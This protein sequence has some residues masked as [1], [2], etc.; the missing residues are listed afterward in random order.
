MEHKNNKELAVEAAVEFVKSWNA[1]TTNVSAKVDEFIQT[2]KSVYIALE[3]I[4]QK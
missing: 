1:K 4:D 3:E 2:I